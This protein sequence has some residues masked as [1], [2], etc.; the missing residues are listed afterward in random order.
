MFSIRLSIGIKQAFRGHIGMHMAIEC[1]PHG[2]ET[3]LQLELA[4]GPV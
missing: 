4:E 1:A 2:L 3:A